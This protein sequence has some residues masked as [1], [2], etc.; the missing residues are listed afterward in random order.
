MKKA[1]IDE[2]ITAAS[3][4][5]SDE[6]FREGRISFTAEALPVL[7]FPIEKRVT[8]LRA[9]T[10]VLDAPTRKINFFGELF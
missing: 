6:R 4:I 1:S 3:I 10:I 2:I 8:K 7:D 9:I 5:K